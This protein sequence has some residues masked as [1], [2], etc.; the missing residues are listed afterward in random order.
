MEAA[1]VAQIATGAASQF[2]REEKLGHLPM[3]EA[4]AYLKEYEPK[5]GD[6]EVDYQKLRSSRLDGTDTAAEEGMLKRSVRTLVGPGSHH[7]EAIIRSQLAQ[8]IVRQYLAVL[9]G[10]ETLGDRD[11]AYFEAPGRIVIRSGAFD[12]R[13]TYGLKASRRGCR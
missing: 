11:T 3:G 13:G 2:R 8:N 12:V 9:A 5:L 7:G 4:F 10:D 1:P 6:L